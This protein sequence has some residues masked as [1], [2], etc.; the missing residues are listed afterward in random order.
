M[1]LLHQLVLVAGPFN[2][3]HQ[4][5]EALETLSGMRLFGAFLTQVG[6]IDFGPEGI[7]GSVQ[8]CLDSLLAHLLVLHVVEAW[9]AVAVAWRAVVA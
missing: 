4:G 9:F 1:L 5:L 7:W 8:R 6:R 3:A 2:R